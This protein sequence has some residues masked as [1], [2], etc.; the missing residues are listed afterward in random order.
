MTE[1][2]PG[3]RVSLEKLMTFDWVKHGLKQ[4]MS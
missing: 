2:K 1:K 4:K 3:K